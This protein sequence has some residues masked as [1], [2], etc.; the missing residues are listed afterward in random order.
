[1]VND[2]V[3]HSL[4]SRLAADSSFR[5]SSA[6]A[7][8][9]ST[10]S[11]SYQDSTGPAV[12]RPAREWR[13][14]PLSSND[15]PPPSCGSHSSPSSSKY[16]AFYITTSLLLLKV[17]Q[18]LHSST[19]EGEHSHPL[20]KGLLQTRKQSKDDRWEIIV[21]ILPSLLEAK[22]LIIE[23]VFL[24]VLLYHQFLLLL[25]HLCHVLNLSDLAED[26]SF[27]VFVEA[28]DGLAVVH[29][30]KIDGGLSFLFS[31]LEAI[32]TGFGFESP[33]AQRTRADCASKVFLINLS[34]G[35]SLWT[36]ALEVIAALVIVLDDAF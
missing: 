21:E 26:L 10:P 2:L 29:D 14:S 15:R 1:M 4:V 17:L 25:I 33:A 23:D 19:L 24:Q 22:G 20:R 6:T 12:R 5:L 8:P 18:Q 31:V 16:D 36:L 7:S 13:I 28:V 35:F 9:L 32:V 3:T 27:G 11:C 34:W 30:G